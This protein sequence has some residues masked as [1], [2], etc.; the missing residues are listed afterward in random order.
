[1]YN[2]EKKQRYEQRKLLKDMSI[3]EVL[4]IRQHLDE[5]QNKLRMI[6]HSK[7]R[8]RTKHISK[9][10]IMECIKQGQ[11]IEFHQVNKQCRVLLRNKTNKGDVCVVVDILNGNIITAYKNHQ[12]DNHSTLREE[13][14]NSKLN[15]VS[16]ILKNKR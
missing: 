11:L 8:S 3:T 2:L 13:N 15:V 4:I 1:M 7:E 10:E 16:V 14:Y 5:V 6:D 12:N 9:R